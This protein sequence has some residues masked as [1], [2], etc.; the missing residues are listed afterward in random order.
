MI[1]L[2][3]IALMV[4]QAEALFPYGRA[5]LRK[6]MC[7]WEAAYCDL[8]HDSDGNKYLVVPLV[9]LFT[10]A[11]HLKAR[12][13]RGIPRRLERIIN[14]RAEFLHEV[15]AAY[16]RS[17]SVHP[18]D[19][20]NELVTGLTTYLLGYVTAN[21]R[22]FDEMT[23]LAREVEVSAKERAMSIRAA[24]SPLMAVTD[25]NVL[26]LSKTLSALCATCRDDAFH[27]TTFVSDAMRWST[28]G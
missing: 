7:A 28:R 1:P 18:L 11:H 4:S 13:V 8:P 2:G 25:E 21:L 26:Q 17:A 14:L 5:S 22:R 16:R 3:E 9:A 6:Y 10:E 27:D 12:G 19:G 15:S 20:V 23:H 24:V